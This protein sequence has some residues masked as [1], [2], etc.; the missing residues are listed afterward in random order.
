MENN[1]EWELARTW[2]DMC[3]SMPPVPVPDGYRSVY[4]Y[5]TA[6]ANIRPVTE[7]FTMTVEPG[8][9]WGVVSFT[10]EHLLD[11]VESGQ[12]LIK[13]QET[14]IKCPGTFRLVSQVFRLDIS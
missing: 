1:R 3:D 6:A 10:S 14:G 2:N 13:L 7:P 5:K 4:L 9:S 8:E 12:Y 11:D